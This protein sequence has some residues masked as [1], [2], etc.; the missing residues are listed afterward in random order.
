MTTGIK[1]PTISIIHATARVPDGWISAYKS[2]VE[3]ADNLADVEYVLGVDSDSVEKVWTHIPKDFIVSIAVNHG[4]K[5][6]VDAWNAAAFCTLGKLIVSVADDYFSAPHWDTMLKEAVPNLDGEY[7]VWA[8]SGYPDW[9]G[10]M[11]HPIFTRAYYMRPGRGGH[12]NG[13]FLYPGYISVGSDDD[14]TDVAKRD[15]VVVDVRDRIVF[16]HRHRSRGYADD[17]VYQW[18][19]R[20]EAWTVRNEVL[21]RRR[22]EGFKR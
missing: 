12:P 18:S 8:G 19:N 15:G 13:E 16:D 9:D 5:C 11:T 3:N 14:F 22:A 4:R 7:V 20:Q 2:W 21:E 10:I 1:Y 6:T 17:N